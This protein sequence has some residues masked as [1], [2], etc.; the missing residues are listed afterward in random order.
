MNQVSN[1]KR[2]VNITIFILFDL[3]YQYT[4]RTDF[5]NIIP[6]AYKNIKIKYITP[7]DIEE[8]KKILVSRYDLKK[9][10]VELIL[11]HGHAKGR[12]TVMYFALKRKMD[13][14][15]FWDD[16]EY[17][18]AVVKNE[19]K[20]L[21]WRKQ[22]NVQDHIHYIEKADITIGHHCGYISP[23]P[24]MQIGDDITEEAFREYIEGIS[25][26][27]VNW[28]NIKERFQK[29]SGVTYAKK[30][31][32][33]GKPYEIEFDG[34]GK[35]I[36]GST[37]CLNLKSL[38]K[39]PAFYNPKG[40]RG[41][42]TFFSTL[43]KEAKVL[44][45]PTYHFH[46]GFLKYTQIM[47]ERMPKHLRKI[48]VDEDTIEHRFKQ[49]SLGWIKYK[50]LLMYIKQKE[51]YKENILEVKQKLE[52]SIPQIDQL[53]EN[54]DFRELIMALEEADENVKKHHKEYL[55]T[56]EVWNKIKHLI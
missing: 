54:T 50:P 23:I 4:K 5:Y 46:D 32:L 20:P 37:L 45:I 34:T 31:I 7:E 17:P 43:L 22:N 53:F 14:L 30:E 18:L 1:M 44:R 41:E 49:A 36:A 13:Y 38:D 21:E 8:E 48:N 52:K 11:G 3:G 9:D 35:W 12:N 55:K 28:D 51:H 24:Y 16:D 25:N 47:R 29:D 40:A 33:E 27:I 6:Q 42:D 26:D 56:N 15:L 10:E 19:D 2:P 39:I